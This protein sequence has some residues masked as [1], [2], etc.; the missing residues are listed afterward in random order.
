MF[1]IY[2]R[3]LCRL[4]QCALFAT[5]ALNV[6]QVD[7][8]AAAI[9][10]P[11]SH[12]V[13]VPDASAPPGATL[14]AGRTFQECSHCPR[15]IVVPAGRFTM[16]WTVSPDDRPDFRPDP[17]AR[18]QQK[19]MS[20][21]RSFAAGIFDITRDEYAAFVRDTGRPINSGCD[22]R[23][24]NEVFNDPT[25]NWRNPGFRQTRNNPVVCV[26]WEDAQAYVRW[27]NRLI[28]DARSLPYTGDDGPYRLPTWE[29]AEY[30][31]SG[32]AT[33]DYPWGDKARRDRANYGTDG[34]LP[35]LPV[36]KGRGRW[37]F[38]SPVDAFPPNRFGLYDAVG[39]VRQW[40]TKC[41][42]DDVACRWVYLFGG[43]WLSDPLYLQL[44]QYTS[45]DPLS[46][47]NT[48]G[49]R[50]LRSL[51]LQKYPLETADKVDR[52]LASASSARSMRPGETFRDCALCPKMIALPAG[53][54]NAIP[55]P[56]LTLVTTLQKPPAQV[57]ID[58][59]FAVG[60]FDVTRAE[61]AAFVHETGWR[62]GQGCQ[63]LDS[64]AYWMM[65][66]GTSWRHPGYRQTDRDPVVCVDGADVHAY[67]AWLNEKLRD[68][69]RREGLPQSGSYR[70]LRY[71]EW[72]YAARGGIIG[73]SAFYWGHVPGHEHANYGLE[74]C[75]PCGLV[76]RGRDRWYYTSPVGS[77]PPNNFGLYDIVGNVWQWLDDC[78]P[79]EASPPRTGPHLPT[80]V[81]NKWNLVGGS[82]DDEPYSERVDWLDTADA[83]DE[84]FIPVRN[85]TWGFR[86][87]RSLQ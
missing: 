6:S 79:G 31:A 86:V 24:A 75:G 39:N 34:C 60:V 2:G 52:Q 54:F 51:D 55:D 80:T 1:V 61:Y 73:A 32:G 25:K 19:D 70:L 63:R 20:F 83:D 62:G 12:A 48:V 66:K 77:F 82:F 13:S 11:S 28:R 10:P 14:A 40:T 5:L 36:E 59:D 22:V 57:K 21:P 65:D 9:D 78:P 8:V 38:T 3:C 76:R 69:Q 74:Q 42:L 27:L 4:L 17:S 46:R 50:V 72:L 44:F 84:K 49:F 81:C 85:Y 87:A 37:R 43:S 23:R 29:E 30:E 15:M 26:S 7:A 33:T 47:D 67:V 71:V 58:Y 35:C 64:Q 68:K 53:K 16:R 41:W 56:I 18:P 45:N